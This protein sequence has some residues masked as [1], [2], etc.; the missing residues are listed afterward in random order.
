MQGCN[1]P[2]GKLPLLSVPGIMSSYTEGGSAVLYNLF[3][4]RQV[5]I[6]Y[7]FLNGGQGKT[8]SIVSGSFRLLSTGIFRNILGHYWQVK[9]KRTSG[10]K[11][12]CHGDLSTMHLHDL[13]CNRKG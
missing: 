8:E 7:L 5:I 11:G 13:F 6:L 12:T 4:K 10:I 3:F 2:Q 1:L 9:G